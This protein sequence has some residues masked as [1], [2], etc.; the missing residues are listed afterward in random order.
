MTYDMAIWI[1]ACVGGLFLSLLIILY[2]LALT[3]TIDFGAGLEEIKK[4]TDNRKG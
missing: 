4:E 2:I 1:L 3:I